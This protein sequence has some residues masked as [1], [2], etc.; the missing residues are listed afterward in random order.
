M[1]IDT[2]LIHGGVF[3]D[4]RNRGRQCADLPSFNL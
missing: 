3:G 1:R 2:K 4:A